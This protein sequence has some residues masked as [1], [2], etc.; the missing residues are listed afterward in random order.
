MSIWNGHTWHG[1]KMDNYG[2]LINAVS[3]IIDS[4]DAER[5]QEFRQAYLHAGVP[6]DVVESNIGFTMGEFGSE[7][8]A[9][10]LALFKASHPVFGTTV[11]AS[12]RESMALGALDALGH[13]LP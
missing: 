5:A 3:E 2:D 9:K 10:G 6:A 12:A 11:P 4:G 13:K 7:K 8:M 1:R